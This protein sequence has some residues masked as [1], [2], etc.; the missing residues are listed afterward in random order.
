MTKVLLVEDD[1][2][3]QNLYSRVLQKSQIDFAIANDGV[4]IVDRANIEKPDI[5]IMDVM[6]PG[7]NGMEALVDLK[8][9]ES[10]KSIP[11]VMLSAHEDENL[12]LESMQIGAKR[13]L[14]K[15]MLEPENVIEIILE[16]LKESTDQ[17]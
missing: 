14:I 6:M 7:R 3:L 11:V 15:S 8:K 5:I 16:V 17:N 4:A 1:T 9:D 2:S 12:M 13:Y 10:T